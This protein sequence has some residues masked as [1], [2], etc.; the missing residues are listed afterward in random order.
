GRGVRPAAG[1]GV[2]VVVGGV[3]AVGGGGAFAGGLVHLVLAGDVVDRV[4]GQI[5]AVP[6]GV[7]LVAAVGVGQLVHVVVAEVLRGRPADRLAGVGGGRGGGVVDD[8]GDVAD[9]VVVVVQV[10]EDVALPQVGPQI[11]QPAV[12]DVVGVQGP[13]AVFGLPQHWLF[14]FVVIQPRQILV[15]ERALDATDAVRQPAG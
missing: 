9:L 2:A 14:E 11:G 7:G 10:L 12:L 8:R 15:G 13:G 1:I 3:I 4:V 5:H 6:V